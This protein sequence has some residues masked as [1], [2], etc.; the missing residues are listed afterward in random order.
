MP[1]ENIFELRDQKIQCTVFVLIYMYNPLPCIKLWFSFLFIVILQILSL[2]SEINFKVMD[3]SVK[4]ESYK[5]K[6]K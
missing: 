2:T 3:N 5:N 6:Q 4:M 1:R